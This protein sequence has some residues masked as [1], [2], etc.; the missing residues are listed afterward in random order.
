VLCVMRNE[1]A[2]SNDVDMEKCVI[3]RYHEN[4]IL[5]REEG[6]KIFTKDDTSIRMDLSER[7]MRSLNR[8]VFEKVSRISEVAI[9]NLSINEIEE[10]SERV[11][12]NF[13]NLRKLNMR[14]NYMRFLNSTSFEGLM[15]LEELDLS[16]NTISDISPKTFSQMVNLEMIDFSE[17]CIFHLPEYVFFRNVHLT[18]FQ[19]AN[20]RL[21]HLPH[22]MPTNQ[23]ILTMN[24]STNEFTNMSSILP[25]TNL[26]SLDISHNPLSPKE[27]KIVFSELMKDA[28]TIKSE[29][30][31]KLSFSS[32]SSSMTNSDENENE[33]EFH[34]NGRNHRNPFNFQRNFAPK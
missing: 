24:F 17:N 16:R 13:T 29:L 9:L 2:S 15:M 31:S 33:N 11:F 28:K 30:K 26:V 5:Q 32:S 8:S 12:V 4:G 20:N 7:Q 34:S 25:Y 10:I 19:F 23:F 6:R 22:L 27:M 1:A 14:M 21:S 18:N 3:R